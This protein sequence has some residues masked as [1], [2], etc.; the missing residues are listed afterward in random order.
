MRRVWCMI[1]ISLVAMWTGCDGTK[2][3]VQPEPVPDGLFLHVSSGPDQPH[4]FLMPLQMAATM[5]QSNDVLVFFDIDA[6]NGV[7]KSSPDITYDTFPGSKEQIRKLAN[8]GVILMVCPGCLKAAGYT[9]EDLM[10]G[11]RVADRDTFF[12]FT[13]G[14]ILSLDY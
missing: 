7:V 12:Q 9:P 1:L 6:V 11:V 14:R 13:K 8:Q 2:K 3:T 10:D 4:R 5:S